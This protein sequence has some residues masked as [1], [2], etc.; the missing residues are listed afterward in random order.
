MPGPILG[1]G[2]AVVNET[3]KTLD[4]YGHSKGV[5][6]MSYSPG[7]MAQCV[8]APSTHQKGCGFDPGQGLNGRQPMYAAFSH[9]YFSPPP[10]TLALTL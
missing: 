6:N 4:Y 2:G 5:K 3:D 9:Q 10:L 7:P 8:G 1:T